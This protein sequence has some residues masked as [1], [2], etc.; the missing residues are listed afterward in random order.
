MKYVFLPLALLCLFIASCEKKE[1]RLLN[2][3]AGT[4]QVG[5]VLLVPEIG[6]DTTLTFSSFLLTFLQCDLATSQQGGNCELAVDSGSA[7]NLEYGVLKGTGGDD[8]TLTINPG[9][10][11]AAVSETIEYQLLK[12]VFTYKIDEN[13]LIMTANARQG[14]PHRVNGRAYL[15]KEIIANRR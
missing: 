13:T 12:S 5:Q 2:D 1:A 10:G 4:Y 8:P 6:A 9:R 14:I 3:L 15:I 11:N 7:F